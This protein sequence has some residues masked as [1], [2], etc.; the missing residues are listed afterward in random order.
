MMLYS[1]HLSFTS[2]KVEHSY[3]KSYAFLV[4][5]SLT[6]IGQSI[7]FILLAQLVTKVSLLIVSSQFFRSNAKN[8]GCELALAWPND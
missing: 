1:L 5:I 2:W 7:S 3:V 8:R 4:N 6:T